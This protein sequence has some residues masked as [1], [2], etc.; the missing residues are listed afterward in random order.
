MAYAD[1]VIGSITVYCEASSASP[2]ERRCVAWTI[3]NRLQAHRFGQ[4]FAEVCTAPMQFSSW[5]SD[6]GDRANLARAMRV[7]AG[8]PVM[9]DC[10]A[11]FNAAGIG[12]D[13][14][15]GATHYFDHTMDSNPPSWSAPPAV[16]TLK[17]DKF[18][19]YSHVA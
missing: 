11:A 6:K 1:E 15:G 7:Q 3:F 16:M 9:N 18:R 14:T 19:F 2:F 10:I 12:S 17:T 13:P 5:N 8:D 4:S